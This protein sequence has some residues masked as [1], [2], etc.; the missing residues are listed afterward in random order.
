MR[1]KLLVLPT[2]LLFA[3]CGNDDLPPMVGTGATDDAKAEA[4]FQEAQKADNAGKSKKAIKLYDELADEI[5]YAKRS[6][7]AR[8]RQAELLEQQGETLDAFEAYQSLLT[9]HQG[10]GLYKKALDRQADLAFQAADGGIKNSFLGLKTDLALSKVTKMLKQVADNAPRSPVAARASY[11][12][13]ELYASEDRIPQAVGAFRDVVENYPSSSLAPE[14][15]FRIGEIL[16]KEANEGNQ[17]QA[18][19]GRAKEA[20]EDYLGMFPGHKRNG[21]ARKLISGIGGRDIQNTY[22]IAEFYERKGNISSAKFYYQEVVRR[23]KSGELHDKAKAR[24][25]ALGS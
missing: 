10:S 7:Q 4:I 9:T 19:L 5:P 6:A 17:D 11:K 25:A 24:L 18:N 14:A 22:E 20:F 16:L 13:G 12:I 3:A 15:Q 2:A 21:E 8:Y 1:F 23:A